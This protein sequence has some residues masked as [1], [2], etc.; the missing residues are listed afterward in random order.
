MP[1]VGSG[2]HDPPLPMTEGLR[3]GSEPDRGGRIGE[4]YG[5]ADGG[6]PSGAPETRADLAPSLGGA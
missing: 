6:D 5:Q 4:T 1:T 2:S 3:A